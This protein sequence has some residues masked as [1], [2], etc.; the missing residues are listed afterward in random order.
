MRTGPGKKLPSQLD[1]L[2][3]ARIKRCIAEGIFASL[4]IAMAQRH[5][6]A[7]SNAPDAG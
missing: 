4:S 6:G 1:V 5:L 7:K 2:Q 3:A